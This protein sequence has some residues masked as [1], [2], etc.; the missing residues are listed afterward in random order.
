MR[1]LYLLS[2]SNLWGARKSFLEI[3]KFINR[4]IFIPFTIL[5]RPGPLENEL[6]KI[7]VEYRIIHLPPWRKWNRWR[8]RKEALKEL[9]SFLEENNFSLIHANSHFVT[10]YA[11]KTGKLLELPVITHIR[12]LLTPD[13]IRKYLIQKSDLIICN[14]IA[15]SQV[16]LPHLQQKVKVIYNGIDTDYYKPAP[17]EKV[18]EFRKSLGLS[19]EP[20]LGYLGKISREKGVDILLEILPELKRQGIKILVGGEVRRE[21]DKDLENALKNSGA[22]LLGNV[23]NPPLFYSSIDILFFPTRIESFGRVAVESLSCKT[24]VIASRVG[25]VKEIVE[26]GKTGYLFS[27]ENP[28]EALEKIL[29]LVNNPQKRKEMGE[30]GRKKAQK[31]FE[32]R[33]KV[34]E[35]EEMYSYIIGGPS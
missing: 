20:I 13:K 15:S 21:R 28:R 18:K 19:D 6:R 34:K 3:L 32:I 14:S 31:N 29:I 33:K 9:L 7:Q 10:P 30:E 1:I 12:A 22:V 24:P 26:D 27:L 8:E 25:G 2:S 17:L 16:F 23:D 35:I 11:I 5:P 4:E